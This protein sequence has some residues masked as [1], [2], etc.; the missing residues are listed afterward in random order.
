MEDQ[1]ELCLAEEVE[2]LRRLG[3]SDEEIAGRMGVDVSWVETLVS[4][5]GD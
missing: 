5:E 3:L 2:R 4:P 1:G